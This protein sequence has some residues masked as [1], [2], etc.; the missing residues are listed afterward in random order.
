MD[1]LKPPKKPQ[2]KLKQSDTEIQE[3]FLKLKEKII[4]LREQNVSLR[5]DK[6]N[7]QGRLKAL[8]TAKQ[9]EKFRNMPKL[10]L[11]KLKEDL[12]ELNKLKPGVIGSVP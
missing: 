12:D 6:L 4:R 8:E 2:V 11:K 1:M 5:D 9:M 3:Y 10:T 7:L